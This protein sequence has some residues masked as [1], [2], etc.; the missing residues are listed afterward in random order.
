MES[1]S[2]DHS[3]N[4]FG[5]FLRS[6]RR[7]LDPSDVGIAQARR[8]RTPGLRREEVAELAGIGIDWY[9]RLEQGRMVTP[10]PQTVDSLARALRLN[11]AEHAHLR[12]LA[13]NPSRRAFVRE[14]VP[15]ALLRIVGGLGQPAYLQGQRWDLLAWNAHAAR[16]FVDF[17]SLT[18]DD[19]NILVFMFT[20][21]DARRLF[22]KTWAEEARHVLAQFRLSHDLWA[23]DP[24]FVELVERVKAA[25]A[26]FAT[27]WALHDVRSVAS[28]RK[29]LHLK[30]GTSGAYEYATF[31]P[32]GE[33]GLKLTIY[34]SVQGETG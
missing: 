29:H 14:A 18:G 25:S 10:S 8:R 21:P 2:L 13:K 3:R 12:A 33:P 32:N 30:D 27:W 31:Q 20:N 19:L 9:I 6:R 28:G 34:T 15:E 24:A 1:A 26:E 16:L 17:G 7:R 22:G 5:E 23:G 4:G 11:N